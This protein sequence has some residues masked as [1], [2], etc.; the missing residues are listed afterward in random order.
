MT[1][2]SQLWAKSPAEGN[3]RWQP[4]I[5]HLLDVSVV[6]DAVLMREPSQTRE[7]MAGIIGL[8]WEQ[9]RPW[10]LLVIACH[11]LGKACPA[12]QCKWEGATALLPKCGLRIPPG[13]ETHVNHAFVSQVVLAALLEV[14]QWPEG[15]A[16]LA[17]D[18]VGCHH[19]ERASPTILNDLEGNRRIMG[20]SNWAAARRDLFDALLETFKPQTIPSKEKLTGPDF[21]LLSGLTSFADWIGSN[22]AWFPYGTPE[23]CN[24]L[25]AWWTQRRQ[26][27]EQA[28]DAIGWE[29]RCPLSPQ[30]LPFEETF[31]F[32]PR[33]LQQAVAKAVQRVPTPC[34]LLVEAPMGEGKT[35][36]AFFAH[37]ELQRRFGHRGL[38]VA[39][40][41]KATG[42]AMFGRTLEFLRGQGPGRSLDLQLLHGATPLN[43]VFQNLRLSGIH[44]SE[45]EGG[46][47]AAEWFTHKKARTPFGIW[48]RDGGSGP[49]DDSTRAASIRASVGVG[50]PRYC[51]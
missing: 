17:A 46:V 14:A 11:D 43:D 45:T 42:N 10:L 13:V 28:L 9:A 29:P 16:E 18:A 47:R 7:R 24:D 35:E 3:V 33:P 19:G 21:M 44:D 2:F 36:A 12:F 49:A 22:E 41:T 4:L 38:Y 23:D 31:H 34:I 5:L 26:N 25:N 40:P 8:P 32:A 30:T 20:G 39:L 48:C 1:S 37:L 6:A 15:L 27:A 50:Q 51:L